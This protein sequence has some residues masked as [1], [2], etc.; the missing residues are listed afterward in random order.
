MAKLS[1]INRPGQINLSYSRL[2]TLHECPRKFQIQELNGHSPDRDDKY[3]IMHFAYGHAV[4]AGIQALFS[5]HSISRAKLAAVTEYNLKNLWQ[6]DKNN[7]RLETVF[8]AIDKFVQW[9][10]A[11]PLKDWEI[12]R[13][14]TPDGKV[15]QAIELDF[16]IQLAEGANYQG[17]ID[18]VLYNRSANLFMVLELKTGSYYKE[19]AY[20]NSTQT[21][22]YSLITDYI[23]D[24]S[25]GLLHIENKESARASNTVLYLMW[26]TST[27]QFHTLPL[28]QSGV[29]KAEFIQELLFDVAT[30]ESMKKINF[31]PKRG[32]SCSGKF[33]TQ[34][35][36]YG[37]CDLHS[38]RNT[39]RAVNRNYAEVGSATI[40]VS[41]VDLIGSQ[42]E[43]TITALTSGSD[44]LAEQGGTE[45]IPNLTVVDGY[46]EL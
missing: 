27:L 43:L 41:V 18:I 29:A 3:S 25:E 26:E 38:L 23:I 39:V 6:N 46:Q 11:G 4:A 17:H 5:G 15:V 32:G 31:F 7:K 22:G 44:Y 8:M 34:C 28:S 33:G 2:Q 30:I 42:L 16:Y 21:L 35:R 37:S 13:F 45:V 12:A 19:S 40:E 36:Y 1:Y 10:E 24:N 20:R 9:I 14:R